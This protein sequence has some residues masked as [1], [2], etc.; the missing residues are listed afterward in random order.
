MSF[1]SLFTRN[2]NVKKEM[3]ICKYRT[4]I[5]S[6]AANIIFE[7]KTCPGKGDL[8]DWVC[9]R[10][11]ITAIIV[12]FNVSNIIFSDYVETKYTGAPLETLKKAASIFNEIQRSSQTKPLEDYSFI[13]KSE[14]VEQ[15]KRCLLC[16]NNP[17]FMFAKMKK[18][19]EKS[20]ENLFKA[21]GKSISGLPDLKSQNCCQKCIETTKGD[22]HYIQSLLRE[23]RTFVMYQAFKIVECER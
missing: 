15:K 11:A 2:K 5:D 14:L 13:K 3:T 21:F 1:T 6:D 8:N 19:G 17:S 4:Q 10:E 16:K 7:C 20:L 18:E 12:E 9:V 22:L 23:L